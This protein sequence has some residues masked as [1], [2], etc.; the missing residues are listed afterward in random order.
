MARRAWLLLALIVALAQPARA[1][2]PN[3][4]VRLRGPLPPSNGHRVYVP[5]VAINH[6]VDGRVHVV[7]GDAMRHLGM[8]SSGFAGLFRPSGDG[9]HLYVA[10][11]FYERL[12]RG[13]RIDALLVYDAR[14]LNL[15][16]EVVIPP[17]HAQAIPYLPYL[18]TAGPHVLVQNAT[19]A[20]SVSVVDPEGGRFL[21]E[22]ETAGCF[23]LYPAG[24]TPG[25]FSTLCGDGSVLTLDLD[26]EG[27]EVA[28]QS[29]E[30]LF[31][32]SEDPLFISS[33]AW[34]NRQVFISFGG[35]VQVLDMSG[36]VARR[37]AAFGILDRSAQQQR[38]R[39]GGRELLAVHAP[40][41]S[42]FVLMHRNA[43]DGSHKNPSH[44]VWRV[45]LQQRRVVA[46]FPLAGV[47][48]VAVTQEAAPLVFLLHESGLLERRAFRR[49]QLVAPA[50]LPG[51]AE[52][53]TSLVLQ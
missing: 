5:D 6:I 11:T 20:S 28:R 3:E 10:T 47:A 9:R 22:V 30:R 29:S 49:G 7:D 34:G 33:A 16:R 14:R 44:Q 37:E 50:R 4:E 39:P 32:A 31:D 41:N 25:R 51:V 48:S 45:D 19:P 17:K 15:V 38:W 53:A 46:R 24:G 26:A 1:D 36:P 40:S 8:V 21:G 27:R 52:A 18:V 35:Q 2:E 43:T 23:G 13:R 42:L 12:I